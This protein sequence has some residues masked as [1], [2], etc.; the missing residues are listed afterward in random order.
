MAYKMLASVMS[1]LA[2]LVLGLFAIVPQSIYFLYASVASLLDLCQLGVRK[3]AGLDVYYV[4]GKAVSGDILKN[5]FDG[6]IG[7]NNSYGSLNTVF[8]AM[9]IFGGMVLV[10]STIFA[11]IRSHYEEET[12]KTN[13]SKI[14]MGACKSL[15]LMALIPVLTIFGVRL[16]ELFL[17]TMDEITLTSTVKNISEVYDANAISN[18]KST[19]EKNYTK[20]YTSFDIFGVT[21]WTNT[22]TFSGMMFDLIC[23]DV[24]RVRMGEYTTTTM[25]N[26]NWDNCSVF[27]VQDSVDNKTEAVAN[28]I[29]YAFKNCLTLE[30]GH[31][32]SMTGDESYCAMGSSLVSGASAIFAAGLINVKRFSKFNVGL[33]WY[34]YNLWGANFFLGFAGAF[35]LGILLVKIVFGLLKRLI[36]SIALFL[37]YA[38]IAG[39]SPLDG[40]NG[41]KNWGKSFI[42]YI[43]ATFGSVIGINLF[44]LL[45]PALSNIA[46]FGISFLDKI[47]NM[48]IILAAITMVNKF[49]ALISS[50]VGGADL[51]KE[52]AEVQKT[53]G[54]AAK[55]G[56][57]GT[58]AATSVGAS[59]FK[60]AVKSGGIVNHGLKAFTGKNIGNRIAESAKT[61][62]ISRAKEKIAGIGEKIGGSKVAGVIFGA[63]G[64]ANMGKYLEAPSME[65]NVSEKE[66]F[67]NKTIQNMLENGKA[68]SEKTYNEEGEI[69][70]Y[71]VTFAD[72][73]SAKKY[74]SL[75]NYN[76]V[77]SGLLKLGNATLKAVGSATGLQNVINSL[78][79]DGI[80]DEAK[81]TVQSI[82]PKS[83]AKSMG[84]GNKGKYFQT[85]KQKA[86]ADKKKEEKK[87][88]KADEFT[89]QS[90]ELATQISTLTQN[91]KNGGS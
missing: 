21:E 68:T 90:K 42:S 64:I 29:D 8:W 5:F 52:G 46:F 45:L 89:T 88:E 26:S 65:V 74:K 7:L 71:K 1:K 36:I 32:V 10:L 48:M 31:T 76:N 60:Y 53:A 23:S 20:A 27:Y 13:P 77:K 35:F 2:D 18:F 39:I 85:A 9:I 25:S 43:I 44:F 47:F 37:I 66:Y 75:S 87:Y 56:L 78:A 22:Q 14:I 38:P 15:C 30:K 40:G 61:G 3:L 51:A 63:L 49:I 33:V 58:L 54:G 80:T 69:T 59:M 4:D 81:E 28:Q 11:I 79:K 19:D 57:S 72:D 82:M 41:I 86:K 62:V 16:S 55:R 17:Q 24:N 34:Y 83:I 84:D 50:F 91:I 73:E 67:N 6:I 70:G 12:A